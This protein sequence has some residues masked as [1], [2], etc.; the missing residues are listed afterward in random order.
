[1]FRLLTGAVQDGT[2]AAGHVRGRLKEQ[3]GLADTG[4]A[5]EQD[6]R[7]RHDAASEHAIEFLDPGRQP[8]VLLDFDFGVQTG[9]AGRPAAA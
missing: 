3:C 4:L 1:M 2:D 5:A 7:P 9:G 6:E 8:G